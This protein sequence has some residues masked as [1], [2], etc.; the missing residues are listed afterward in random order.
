LYGYLKVLVQDFVSDYS[1]VWSINGSDPTTLEYFGSGASLTIGPWTSFL[2][3]MGEVRSAKRNALNIPLTPWIGPVSWSMERQDLLP[4]VWSGPDIS[5]QEVRDKIQELGLCG[6]KGGTAN[7]WHKGPRIGFAD[8][9]TGYN[10]KEHVYYTEV[11]GNSAYYFEFVRHVL[12][13]GT[14]GIGL[15]NPTTFIDYGVTGVCL[16]TLDINNSNFSQ[17]LI[18]T[19]F[20]SGSTAHVNELKQLD[21]TVQDTLDKIGGFT[22][23]T[24]DYSK[25]PWNAEWV[26]SGAPGLNGSTWWWRIT[27]NPNYIVTVDGNTVLSATGPGMWLGTTGPTLGVSISSSPVLAPL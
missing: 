5:P 16:A 22:L 7:F 24:A 8:S 1:K 18:K 21:D 12:L 4:V 17:S 26:A 2:Q 6:T 14:K 13:H 11:S 25:I 10:S 27:G 23:T 9:S 19:Y 15:F 20:M 3:A